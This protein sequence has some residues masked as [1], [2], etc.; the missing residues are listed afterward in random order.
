MTE[1]I[2]N[3]PVIHATLDGLEGQA[4][5]IQ[6]GNEECSTALGQGQ[7]VWEG[8]ASQQWGTEQTRFNGRAQDF[9]HA[10]S[11]YI[12]AV[13]QATQGQQN[14]EQLNQARFT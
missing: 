1:Q 13:R 8:E 5:I 9:K 7:A 10:V 14:T 2:W 6:A 3:F 12:N 4:N 11:D